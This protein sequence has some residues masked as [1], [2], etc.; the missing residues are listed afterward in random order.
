MN[1]DYDYYDYL[2]KNVFIYT[3]TYIAIIYMHTLSIITEW[4]EPSVYS[5][6]QDILFFSYLPICEQILN[7]F[8]NILLLICYTKLEGILNAFE[9]Y[10]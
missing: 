8:L 3:Y 10:F 1:S 6:I 7:Q 9:K 2:Y 4:D 5:I